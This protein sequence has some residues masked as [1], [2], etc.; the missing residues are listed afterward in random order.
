[1]P[2][3]R[4]QPRWLAA[5]ALVLAAAA[6][7]QAAPL[8]DGYAASSIGRFSSLAQHRSDPRYDEVEA[9]IVPIW[10]ERTDGLWL[11]QEQAVLTRPG[12]A[13]VDALKAPYFQR[14]GQVTEATDGTLR[15]ANFSLKNPARFIGLGR[16][17]YVGP[18]PVP[19]AVPTASCQ[20][21]PGTSPPP[22]A[23]ALMVFAA[24]SACRASP[25][26]RPTPMPVGIAASTLAASAYGG[27]KAGATSF[28]GYR[29]AVCPEAVCPEAAG[30]VFAPCRLCRRP[31]RG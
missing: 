5:A 12:M 21:L 31:A 14:I 8:L 10:P 26:P 22:P 20:W 27:P 15:R 19:E 7:A 1:M 30:N 6:P 9:V 23:P 16:A 11:Y 3:L 2:D 4:K 25:S 17:G 18:M 24:R 29:E 13:R 28:A